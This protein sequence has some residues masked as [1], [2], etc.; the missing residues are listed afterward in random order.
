MKYESNF[1]KQMNVKKSKLNIESESE[2]YN[3]Q[4]KHR[5]SQHIFLNN[6]T[7]QNINMHNCFCALVLFEKTN[8]D[9]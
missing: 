7:L 9:R 5:N 1:K 3:C 8:I 6:K 4:W 2:I